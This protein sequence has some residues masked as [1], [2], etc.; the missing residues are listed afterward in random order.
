LKIPGSY[1]PAYLLVLSLL[2]ILGPSCG[3]PYQPEKEETEEKIPESDEV[4]PDSTLETVTWN[5]NWYGSNFSGP[6][7][8]K[9]QTINIVRVI[10]SLEADLYAFQEV[11]QQEDLNN[12]VNNM[13]GYRGFTG[14]FPGNQSQKMAFIFNT[15]TI[16]SL[17]AGLITD[18]PEEYKDEWD[19]YWAN[20]RLPLF[21]SFTYTFKNTTKEFYAI[22]IHGK[23][24][25]GD[26]NQEYAEAYERR[27]KAAEGL[28]YHLKENKS[29]ASI[30]LLGDYNDDV[31]KSI[32]SD[33]EGQYAET[34][35]Y[36]FVNDTENFDVI[37]KKLSD[38][39]EST[40]INYK[41]IIDHI[42]IS[43][44]L[45]DNYIQNSTTVYKEP[46]SYIENYGETTS[47]HLP[48]WTKF[49][50]TQTKTIGKND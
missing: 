28:Y 12:I 31:D 13:K 11:H 40:S 34:P 46:Q 29:E 43:D 5:L 37:T 7:D 41:N 18:A 14:E 1:N 3:T 24:N 35:Y 44:D 42:T 30:I 16:D 48:V 25:S 17:E 50:V 9:Q 20:G 23:A 47:D 45:F 8:Q 21:F 4:P 36:Q 39:G 38:A 6:S 26:N 33:S 19:Y 22:V 49:D 15:N 2:L 27:K 32:Y 10:D